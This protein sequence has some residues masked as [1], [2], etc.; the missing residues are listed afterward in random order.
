ML[1]KVLSYPTCVPIWKKQ[2]WRWSIQFWPFNGLHKPARHAIFYFF[3]RAQS[4]ESSTALKN[5][6]SFLYCSSTLYSL[7]L[8]RRY[9]T[10]SVCSAVFC[11]SCDI[12]KDYII[13]TILGTNIASSKKET[14]HMLKKYFLYFYFLKWDVLFVVSF[15]FLLYYLLFFVIIIF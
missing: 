10:S 4:T 2:K 13:V 12:T 1:Q 6:N 9:Y 8:P 5:V 3:S 7:S 11:W 15:F 14:K